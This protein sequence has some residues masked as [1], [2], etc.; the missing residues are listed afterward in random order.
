MPAVQLPQYLKDALEVL[1]DPLNESQVRLSGAYHVL[2]LSPVILDI[3]SQVYTA[4]DTDM[5]RYWFS[6]LE[7]TDPPIQ[8]ITACHSQCI[9]KFKYLTMIC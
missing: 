4:L 1:R 3:A 8:N 7:M 2:E 5:S 9:D 6:F